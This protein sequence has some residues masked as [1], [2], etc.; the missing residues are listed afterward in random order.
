MLRA[1]VDVQ[2]AAQEALRE[3][4]LFRRLSPVELSGLAS[5]TA[6]HNYGKNQ[7]IFLQGARG[8]GLYVVTDGH[9]AISRQGADGNELILFVHEPG[10]YFGELSLFDDE[11]RS[12]TA[13]A[14]DNCD[15]LFLPRAGFRVFIEQHPAA[16]FVCLE[17]IV[18]QLRRLT[19]LAD[20]IAL[21]DIRSRLARRL[22]KL[23]DRGE[24]EA[25]GHHASVHITQQHLASMLGATRESVNKHL[26]TLSQEGIIQLDR[27]HIKV[28]DLERL[29]DCGDGL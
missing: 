17:V 2:P 23:V 25:P 4:S 12:A 20:E 22:L 6:R 24:V 18:R 10:E 21:L 14:I 9:V 1:H 28:L 8:D 3:V 29:Q 15:V 5:Q 27:G 7:I 13:T 19:D 16:V 26:G 11:P